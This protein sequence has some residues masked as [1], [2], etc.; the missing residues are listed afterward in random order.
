MRKIILFKMMVALVWVQYGYAQDC[1]INADL[2]A[3]PG[4]YLTAAEYPWPAERAEY[5]NKMA[6]AADK[7]MAKQTLGQIEKIEQQSH[8]GFSLTGSNW[9]NVYSTEGYGYIANTK[10][11]QYTFQSAPTLFNCCIKGR[12]F[13]EPVCQFQITFNSDEKQTPKIIEETISPF[14]ICYHPCDL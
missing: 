7:A 10:L 2:D 6:T 13:F 1:K 3:T 4:K 5:F 9:E 14:K 8:N 12:L 11:G